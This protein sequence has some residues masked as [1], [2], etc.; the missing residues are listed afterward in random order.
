MNG[1]AELTLNDLD[2]L[3]MSVHILFDR[4]KGDDHTKR[5]SALALAEIIL[6]RAIKEA[7]RE[8]TK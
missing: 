7:K 8:E 4:S 6:F 2:D 3:L 5:S 1:K